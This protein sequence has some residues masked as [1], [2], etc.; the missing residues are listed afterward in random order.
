MEI[1]MPAVEISMG[2]AMAHTEPEIFNAIDTR[3]PLAEQSLLNAVPVIGIAHIYTDEDSELKFP[4]VDLV[5]V[6]LGPNAQP[7]CDKFQ[8]DLL[9]NWKW[10]EFAHQALAEQPW[11]PLLEKAFML[12]VMAESFD[13]SIRYAL[14]RANL[15]NVTAVVITHDPASFPDDLF[16]ILQAADGLDFTWALRSVIGASVSDTAF[17]CTDLGDIRGCLRE[18]RR[19]IQHMGSASAANELHL[20]AE[21]ALNHFNIQDADL[22]RANSVLV[23]ISAGDDLVMDD[24][25][26]VLMA[27]DGRVSED[28]QVIVALNIEP[29]TSGEAKVIVTAG[30]A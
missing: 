11:N 14:Q 24:Y 27:V 28:C 13:P 23:W 3:H 18:A 15:F 8:S 26:Q 1:V 9:E 17:G 16:P 30:W 20:A 12:F 10:Y 2:L 22:A 4:S 5:T 7:H 21:Q 6:F 25:R 29:V 19:L